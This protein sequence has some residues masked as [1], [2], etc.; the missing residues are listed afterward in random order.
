MVKW[1]TLSQSR[2]SEEH[3]GSNPSRITKPQ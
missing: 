2:C 3:L 1:Q